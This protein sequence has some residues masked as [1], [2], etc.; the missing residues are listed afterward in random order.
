MYL[1]NG[2]ERKKGG[3]KGR[4]ILSGKG[5]GRYLQM[6]VSKVLVPIHVEN[7]GYKDF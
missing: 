2:E 4:L 3:E 5:T 7:K 1:S 6:L